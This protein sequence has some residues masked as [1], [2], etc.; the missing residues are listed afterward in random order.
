MTRGV[1][2]LNDTLICRCLVLMIF[3]IIGIQY[4][5]RYI[6][7]DHTSDVDVIAPFIPNLFKHNDTLVHHKY[8]IKPPI[9]PVTPK[10]FQITI[11]VISNNRTLSLKRL[12]HSLS[13]LQNPSNILINLRFSL[14]AS[15]SKELVNYVYGYKWNHGHKSVLQRVQKGGLIRAVSESWFPASNNDYGMLLEDDIEVSP[16][17]IIWIEKILM[18]ILNS[19]ERE[20][21]AQRV[22]GISLYQPKVTET[23]EYEFNRRKPFYA[24]D[25]VHE[26]A[27]V[28]D[29]P[30]LYQTP[31]SWGA[32]YFPD[33]WKE[34]LAY[35][36]QRV[37]YNRKVSIPYSYTSGWRASWKKY[38]FEFMYIKGNFLVYPNFDKVRIK[39][40]LYSIF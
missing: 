40:H 19:K 10:D 31:C 2:L 28:D 7:I 37:K 22:I 18:K 11:A 15:S 32:V 3:V 12:L 29:S 9:S 26:L 35:L 13:N 24:R 21:K 20:H 4:A 17:T 14:E 27:K 8:P 34:F 6:Q 1:T 25:I 23:N 38:L 30:Y 5:S 16:Y 39:L 33:T 36:A